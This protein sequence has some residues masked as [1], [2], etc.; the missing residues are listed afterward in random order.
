MSWFRYGAG[1]GA[2]W[3]DQY[4]KDLAGAATQGLPDAETMARIAAGHDVEPA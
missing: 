3:L 2:E 1:D 4:L